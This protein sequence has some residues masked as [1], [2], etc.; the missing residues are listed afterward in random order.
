VVLAAASSTHARA[1]LPRLDI[2]TNVH[3]RAENVA[4]AAS[5]VSTASTSA[6][7]SC[8]NDGGT[9]CTGLSDVRFLYL[10]ALFP[11]FNWGLKDTIHT[12]MG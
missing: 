3:E 4:A 12:N 5:S 11:S 1:P 10:L 8:P 6:A 2:N 7:T 9:S